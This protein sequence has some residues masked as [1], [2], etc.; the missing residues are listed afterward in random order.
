MK[1]KGLPALVQLAVLTLITSF[2]W[3][4]FEVFRA[5][6]RPADIEVSPEILAP[7]DPSLDQIT[8][9]RLV[10]RVFLTDEEIGDTVLIDAS[11]GQ[12]AARIVE[13]VTIEEPEEIEIATESAQN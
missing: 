10:N 13:E 12:P 6:T 11:S 5:F 9:D 8:L 1:K 7:L 4:S 3:V 2:V